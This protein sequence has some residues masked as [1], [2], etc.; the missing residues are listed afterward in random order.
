MDLYVAI[1]KAIIDIYSNGLTEKSESLGLFCVKPEIKKNILG[2]PIVI[3]F[4][5]AI[6][7]EKIVNRIPYETEYRVE[8]EDVDCMIKGQETIG[9]LSWEIVDKATADRLLSPE[10]LKKYMSLSAE[11][12]NNQLQSVREKA[13]NIGQT[14][15]K[16]L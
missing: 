6:T 14:S 15:E 11:E 7:G 1:P 16:S 5:E 10:E 3:G 13:L 8:Y 4:K 9:D 2:K 12:V